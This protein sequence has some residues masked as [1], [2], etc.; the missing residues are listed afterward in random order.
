MP[1]SVITHNQF[2]LLYD[3][4]DEYVFYM[5]KEDNTSCTIGIALYPYDGQSVDELLDRTDRTLY[6]PKKLGKNNY[7]YTCAVHN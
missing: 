2:Q 5:R 7:I 1:Q 3:L 6:D 4:A